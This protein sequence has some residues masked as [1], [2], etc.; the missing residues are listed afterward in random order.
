MPKI[1]ANIREKLLEEAKKQVM[2]Q[3]YA[4]MTIRSVAGACGVGVGT[5]YNYFASKDMLVASFMLED[6]NLCLDTINSGSKK[7]QAGSGNGDT[8]AAGEKL[9]CIIHEQL[10]LFWK[11]YEP[12]FLDKNAGISFASSFPVRHQQLRSQIA[13][14]LEAFCQVKSDG[15]VSA[16]FLA[17]FIAESLLTWTMAGYSFE[18]IAGVLRKLF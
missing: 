7:L 1:I 6:W 4:S 17:E 5:V 16:A 13:Q 8:A 3:G 14:P 9:L 2:E 11:K 18:Q 10:M 12:L 15:S